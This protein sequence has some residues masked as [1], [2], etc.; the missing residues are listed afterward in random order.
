MVFVL[1][2]KRKSCDEPNE[3]NHGL[4]PSV[5]PKRHRPCLESYNPSFV[6]STLGTSRSWRNNPVTKI[7][8]NMES[9]NPT[10]LTATEFDDQT[11]YSAIADESSSSC[12][13]GSLSSDLDSQ[14]TTGEISERPKLVGARRTAKY[15]G[16][17][18]ATLDQWLLHRD[19][20]QPNNYSHHHHSIVAQTT[21]TAANEPTYDVIDPD[22]L[23]EADVKLFQSA[24]EEAPRLFGVPCMSS[25]LKRS[26]TRSHTATDQATLYD[27]VA[28]D[29][30][31]DHVM[32]LPGSDSPRDKAK[33]RP[34]R[35]Y[36]QHSPALAHDP[37][38]RVRREYFVCEE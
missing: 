4:G 9:F 3:D 16:T 30:D 26:G 14:S 18:L 17:N 29:T 15:M 31:T 6:P 21:T 38:K 12:A 11:I 33:I 35:R 34:R 10:Y 37:V 24:D 8:S 7:D 27:E 20:F 19:N 36:Y 13:S 5:C 22:G 28:S 25:T 2:Q 23:N 32:V 1:S